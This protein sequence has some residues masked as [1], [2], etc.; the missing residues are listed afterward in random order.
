MNSR[1]R[2]KEK[3]KNAVLVVLF[4]LAILLLYLLWRPD[5]VRSL[6]LSDILP[7]SGDRAYVPGCEEVTIPEKLIAGDGSGSFTVRTTGLDGAFSRAVELSKE[8]CGGSADIYEIT[9]EQFE[10]ARD[11]YPAAFL[12]WNYSIPVQEFFDYYGI[13]AGVSLAALGNMSCLGFSEAEESSLFVADPEAGTFYRLVSESVHAGFTAELAKLSGE[14]GS[15]CYPAYTIL[16][17]TNRTLVPLSMESSLSECSYEPEGGADPARYFSTVAETIF[18]ETFDFV[19]RITDGFGN[20]TYMYG[21]GAKTF[22]VYS[23]GGVEYRAETEGSSRGFFGDL[24]TALEFA[25][26]CGAFPEDGRLRYR[27][28]A[29]SVSGTGRLR[30]HEFSFLAY[31][32][33]IPVNSEE[34]YPF[35]VTVSNGGVS[36]YK[37]STFTITGFAS[38]GP[39]AVGDAV[40]TVANNSN[41]MYKVLNGDVL[42]ENSDEAFTFVSDSLSTMSVGYYDSEPARQLIPCWAISTLQGTVFYF[43]LYDG[44]PLGYSG[45]E[46]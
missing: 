31:I 41:H 6:R 19:R 42:S 18:G 12:Y 8:L 2:A 34:G 11:T 13:D 45:Q 10:L 35:T 32:D 9:E 46:E 21:Y 4:I 44:T 14:G 37:R 17:G 30:T 27:L 38:S 16:G 33:G 29:C 28:A 26:K 23:A 15:V 3:L 39:E 1:T 25:G 5:S 20:I 36:G 40:N 24:R 43:D 22:T 7:F